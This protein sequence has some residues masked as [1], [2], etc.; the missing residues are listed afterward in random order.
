M[1]DKKHP[2]AMK[3]A[4]ASVRMEGFERTPEMRNQCECVLDGEPRP[5]MYYAATK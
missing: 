4:E 3:N 1:V 2:S 5:P